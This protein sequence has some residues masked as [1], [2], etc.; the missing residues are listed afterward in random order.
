MRK[1][2]G[3]LLRAEKKHDCQ[4][5]QNRVVIVCL[6]FKLNLNLFETTHSPCRNVGLW[7]LLTEVCGFVQ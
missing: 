5:I 6:M 2:K 3:G 1:E 7:Y 4:S